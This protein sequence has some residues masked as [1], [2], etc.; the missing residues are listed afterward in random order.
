MVVALGE[1]FLNN[2]VQ[3]RSVVSQNE[4]SQVFK[5]LDIFMTPTSQEYK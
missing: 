1:K 5:I 2:K 4:I 3:Y